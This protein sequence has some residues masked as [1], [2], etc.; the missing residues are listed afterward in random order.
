MSDDPSSQFQ[1]AY[2]PGL[3]H[4]FKPK[5]RRVRGFPLQ[6]QTPDG[7]P[8]QLLGLADA[9]QIS[10]RMIATLPAAQFILPLMDGNRTTAE[11]VAEVGRGLTEEFLHNLVSQ[12]DGAG[13]L[14]GPVFDA[15]LLHMQN[16]FDSVDHLPPGASAQFAEAMAGQELGED[17]T[18]ED[19]IAAAPA[20][21]REAMDA[22]IDQALSRAENPSLDHLPKA[23]VAPHIDYP[24]GWVNY[25]SVYGRLRVVDRPDRVII[26]G[27]NHFG[28]STGVTGCD[29]GFASPLGLCPVDTA[30][31]DALRDALGPDDTAKLFANRY[32]HEREHSIELQ[33]PWIQHCLGT[34]EQGNFCSVFGALIHDPAVN[35]GESYDGAGLALDPFIAAMK[36]ALATLPGKTLV[37]SSADLSHVGPA[38]GDRQVL[39]GDEGEPVEFRNRVAKHDQEMLALIRE[40]KADDLVAS[41]AWQQNPTRWCSTGNIVATI[42]IVEPTTIQLLS[43]AAAMDQQGASLVSHAAMTME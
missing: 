30:F 40:G 9:Q 41:M 13:L 7:K 31:I 16:E 18:E 36:K 32:D 1:I 43:Y 35:N 23:I 28:R 8:Q 34:D 19:R 38:F 15:L 6:A 22:W 11:I 3:P 42:K 2:D 12:L 24:R 4:H 10:D 20:K 25:G 26:L 21:L 33:I 14:H 27:T 29:K 37:V 39:A 5:L 17:S